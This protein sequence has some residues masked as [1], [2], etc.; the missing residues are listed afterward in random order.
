MAAERASG[1]FDPR[2]AEVVRGRLYDFEM[3]L[4]ALRQ[5]DQAY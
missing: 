4:R 2:Q 5:G 3:S 1:G